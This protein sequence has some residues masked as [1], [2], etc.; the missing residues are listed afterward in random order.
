[1]KMF[2]W[3]GEVHSTEIMKSIG[4]NAVPLEQTE[5]LTGLQTGLIES[6]PTIPVYAL[7]GQFY[8]PAP[9]MVEVNWVPLNGAAVI[10]KKT[11]DAIPESQR[12][13][14]KKAAAEAGEAIKHRSRVESDEAVAAMKKRGLR[15]QTLTPEL[16][17]E[18]EKFGEAVYPRIRGDIVRT[19]MFDEV[20]RLVKEYR[21]THAGK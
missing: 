8:S 11:W 20:Q 10:T 15:V 4:I 14:M 3:S 1:M 13:E 6:V 16:V 18:W 12:A 17:G 19:E 9:Y 7:A 5:I 2:V 21:A